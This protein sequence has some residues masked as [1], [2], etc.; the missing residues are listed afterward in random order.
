MFKFEH[1]TQKGIYTGI[2][3]ITLWNVSECILL[4]CPLCY[5]AKINNP[6]ISKSQHIGWPIVVAIILLYIWGFIG[7]ILSWYIFIG[8]YSHGQNIWIRFLSSFENY[9]ILVSVVI[10]ATGI[11]C[12]I[13]A[14]SVM[15][16]GIICIIIMKI[17]T[18]THLHLNTRFGVAG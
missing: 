18:V 1:V 7:F 10:G 6:A 13:L 4:L 5:Y 17:L 2:L 15:V 12:S 14:D 8:P 3:S 9:K 11:I 16:C